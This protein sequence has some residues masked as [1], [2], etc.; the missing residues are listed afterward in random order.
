MAEKNLSLDSSYDLWLLIGKIR[1]LLYLARQKEL[2]PYNITTRQAYVLR[3]M[4][5]Q[6]S[7]T[8]LA[9]IASDVNRGI[10]TISIQMSRM[11]KD[12]LIRKSREKPKSTQ[13]S[14][15]LTEKGI[16]AYRISGQIQ[17]IRKIMSVLSEDERQQMLSMLSKLMSKAEKYTAKRN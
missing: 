2:A 12:G 5:S 9:K 3:V 17:S 8:T 7:K 15:E 4:Y 16:E 10:N 14:F 6:G 13:L 1:H 11:E